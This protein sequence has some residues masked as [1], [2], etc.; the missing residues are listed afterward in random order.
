LSLSGK[1]EDTMNREYLGDSYD[2][3]KRLW[4]SLFSEWAPLYANPDFFPEDENLR[5]DFT[6]LTGIQISA[7]HPPNAFSIL[8]DPDVGIRLPREG[9]QRE[10]R[11]HIAIASI[12]E[13]LRNTR[14]RCVITFDQSDYR[15]NELDREQQRQAKMQSLADA[16]YAG[17]YYLSHAPFLFAVRDVNSIQELRKMLGNAGIPGERL[18]SLRQSTR[19]D[20]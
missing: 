13:Q 6:R 12:V 1:K 17:M 11:T 7:K 16:G 14:A 18:E 2:A 4:C 15:N 20:G 5:Q 3:V 8:N 19:E 10:G 9:N